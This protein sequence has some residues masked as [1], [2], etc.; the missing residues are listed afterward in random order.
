MVKNR[1]TGYLVTCFNVLASVIMLLTLTVPCAAEAT[2][3]TA[4]ATLRVAEV[5]T[6]VDGCINVDVTIH[7]A[8]Q[9]L[10]GYDMTISL[11]DAEVATIDSVDLPEF[12][13]SDASRPSPGTTKIRVA[14][15]N[16]LITFETSEARLVT[17]QL[18]GSK[19][20]TSEII[21]ALNAMDD[22]NG[23][24]IEPRIVSGSVKV[25]PVATPPPKPTTSDWSLIGGI[26]G[27]V[28]VIGLCI[29]LFTIR[30]KR[31]ATD[32]ASPNKTESTD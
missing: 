13:L 12:G 22:D 5:V 29:G 24:P 16:D 14:D 11:V 17:L 9:G 21:V 19:P 26:I 8:S 7:Q 20:G 1:T 30:R 31:A 10:S 2:A 25:T 4:N 6:T 32:K 3:A 27:A 23:D 15:L 18:K 28:V